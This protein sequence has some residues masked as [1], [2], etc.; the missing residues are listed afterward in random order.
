MIRLVPGTGIRVSQNNRYT[1]TAT[2]AVE[3]A[4][5]W[6]H[7]KLSCELFNY[8]VIVPGSCYLLVRSCVPFQI[9]CQGKTQNTCT[10]TNCCSIG[11]PLNKKKKLKNMF[12]FSFI[13]LQL[14]HYF[15]FNCGLSWLQTENDISSVLRLELSRSRQLKRAYVIPVLVHD[16]FVPGAGSTRCLLSSRNMPLT[17]KQLIPLLPFAELETWSFLTLLTLFL[18]RFRRQS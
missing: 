15:W 8:T 2:S 12:S 9:P 13:F 17:E 18:L 11:G 10:C 16:I 14:Q 7:E 1:Y 3:P 4:W 5:R 6:P